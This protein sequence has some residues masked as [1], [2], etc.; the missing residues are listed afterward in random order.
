[1]PA[2][3]PINAA[4]RFDRAAGRKLRAIAQHLRTL[5]SEQIAQGNIDISLFD[6]AAESAEQGEPLIVRCTDPVE[7]TLMAKAFTDLGLSHSPI[8]ELNG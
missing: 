2:T 7:V 3:E 5:S 8:D 4:F 6:K 1:M